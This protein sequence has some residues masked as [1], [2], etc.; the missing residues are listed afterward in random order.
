LERAEGG[1]A[2][3]EDEVLGALSPD[4]RAFLQRL[5]AKAIDGAPVDTRV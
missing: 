3:V 2:S 5:L 1:I 4:E